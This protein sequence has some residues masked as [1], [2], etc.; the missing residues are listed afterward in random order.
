MDPSSSL[1]PPHKHFASS[2]LL[3]RF[4]ERA[5]RESK[6]KLTLGLADVNEE[7][8]VLFL[9]AHA[10]ANLLPLQGD[11]GAMAHAYVCVR[12]GKCSNAG[13]LTS[14]FASKCVAHSSLSVARLASTSVYPGCRITLTSLARTDRDK[15][16]RNAFPLRCEVSAGADTGGRLDAAAEGAEA[17]AA[18]SSDC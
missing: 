7:K 16:S 15:A 14:K 11:Q 17:G 10:Q 5:S 4:L 6:G 13:I 12:A 1:V 18:D 8:S 2:K 3:R 9:C